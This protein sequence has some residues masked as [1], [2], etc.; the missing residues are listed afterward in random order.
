MND[1]TDRNTLILEALNSALVV[2][3]ELNRDDKA[4]KNFGLPGDL[5]EKLNFMNDKA[6]SAATTAF[7]NLVT[8]IAI[9]IAYPEIDVR[10]HQTQTQEPQ[11]FNHRGISEKVV[12]PFL[13]DQDF[14]GAKSGWQTRTFE[15]PKPYIIPY[16][17][18]IQVVKDQ[19]LSCYQ[20]LEDGGADAKQMLNYLFLG[21]VVRRNAKK[22]D[23]I[24]PRIDDISTIIGHFEAHFFANYK[25]RGQSR[26]PVLALHSL[27]KLIMPEL[28]RFEGLDLANL[29]LHSAADSQ[30]G[31]TGDIEI[32]NNDGTVFEAIEVKHDIPVS[33][34]LVV[35]AAKKLVTRRV[36]R[37]Y[38]LTTHKNCGQTDEVAAKIKEVRER[39]GC[40]VIANGVIPTMRYYL[41]LVQNPADIFPHYTS[42]LK[43]EPAISHEHRV[44]WNEIVLPD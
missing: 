19:F 29:E 40:Q 39:T 22:I 31:A 36:D 18:N 8:G 21:Q 11:H 17:E 7:T 10:F 3:D 27:Y 2:A 35:D 28:R 14:D 6:D 13:R 24:E 34:D 12:Y 26:L 32:K 23:L 1:Y 9:K 20:A 25:S 4:D 30:T 33:L 43:V 15:R 44:K 41:R 38:V 5:R 37:F 42:L 16:E